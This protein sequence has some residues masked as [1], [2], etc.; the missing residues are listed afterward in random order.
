MAK[1]EKPIINKKELIRLIKKAD[2]KKLPELL[3]NTGYKS[4]ARFSKRLQGEDSLSQA[5]DLERAG[6]D[7]EAAKIY[8]WLA[9]MTNP[10]TKFLK[11]KK[12]EYRNRAIKLYQSA[13]REPESYKNKRSLVGKVVPCIA[14]GGIVGGLIFL[15]P[16]LTA[17][18]IGSLNQTSSNWIGGILFLIG[19]AGVYVSC[20]KR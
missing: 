10:T 18:A 3:I 19:I 11:E 5:R 8:D 16:N 7:F 13:G 1:K 17:N 12:E 15:S 2:E 9:D 6:E 20:R 4:H 14:L